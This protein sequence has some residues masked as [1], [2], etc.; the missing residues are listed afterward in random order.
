[1]EA[2]SSLVNKAALGGF[3]SEHRVKGR[4]RGEVLIS[5]IL[6]GDDTLI[7][8]GDS[9]DH[10]MYLKRILLLFEV[11]SS[12][13][14]NLDK[15][16]IIPVGDMESPKVLAQELGCKVNLLPTTYLG[17]PLG[18]RHKSLAVW[19][20]VEEKF[21][22]KLSLWKRHY[23]SKGGRI[24]LIHSTLVSTPLYMMSIFRIKGC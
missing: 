22:R 4:G 5:H 21:C 16:S 20:N 12:L 19:D 24:T 7:F 14:I 2:F 13:R 8:C 3:L 11:L 6:F 9:R 15:S 23:I 10:M 1:M 18:T 17:L